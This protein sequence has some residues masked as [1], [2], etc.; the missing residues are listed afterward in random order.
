MC[1]GDLDGD[2]EWEKVC[3][4]AKLPVWSRCIFTFS[5]IIF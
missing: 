3:G 5:T 4:V 1:G 2:D